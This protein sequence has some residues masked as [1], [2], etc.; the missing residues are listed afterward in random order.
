MSEGIKRARD[1]K[2]AM[3]ASRDSKIR[4]PSS[5]RAT[6][7]C[8]GCMPRRSRNL[9]GMTT[10]PCGPTRTWACSSICAKLSSLCHRP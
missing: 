1:F 7:V 5:A 3:M 4:R 2:R 9:A 8:P 10:R 6:S